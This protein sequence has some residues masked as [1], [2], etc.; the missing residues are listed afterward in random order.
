MLPDDPNHYFLADN[1]KLKMGILPVSLFCSGHTYFTQD[2]PARFN[3]TPYAVHATFQFS[4]TDGKRHRFRERQL[5]LDGVDYY[6]PA[7]ACVCLCLFVC[8]CVCVS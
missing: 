4:G 7:G 8:V 3:V 5:W 2:M 1:G 6:K